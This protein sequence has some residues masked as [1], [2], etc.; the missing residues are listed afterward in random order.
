MAN[1]LRVRQDFLGGLVEDNPLTSGAT[2]L[3]SNS[4]SAAVAIGSTQHMPIIL[5]PDGIAGEPEIAYIT[6]HVLG[7]GTA[8]I[9]RG[10]EGTSA[11]AHN[12]D[13][14]WLHGPIKSDSEPSHISYTPVLSSLGTPPTLGTGAVA[15]G[16]YMTMGQRVMGDMHFKLGTGFSAGTGA[17]TFSLPLNA[18]AD[19]VLYNLVAAYGFYYDISAGPTYN[20]TA[21]VLNAT[22]IVAYIDASTQA[23]SATQPVVPAVNDTYHFKFEYRRA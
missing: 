21:G 9:L 2:T 11:R 3:T 19:D 16:R 23:V 10:Q 1:E 15:F 14:Y 5:D 22:T 18:H 6:A 13:T 4:L 20:L 17:Y 8:T 7:T 12:R